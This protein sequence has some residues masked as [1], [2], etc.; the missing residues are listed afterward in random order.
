[1]R[2]EGT[3]SAILDAAVELG[4]LRG[5]EELSLGRLASAVGMSKS[6][7]FAHFGSKEELQLATVAQAWEVFEAE[8]LRESLDDAPPGLGELL[9]RWLSF[10]ERRVF[11]GGC[12]F[13]GSATEFASRQ[14]AVSEALANAV[15]QQLAALDAAVRRAN[16]SGELEI[17]RAPGRTAFG[18]FSILVNS[19]SLFHL[20]EDPAAFAR[21]RAA[22]D[23]LLDQATAPERTPTGP[24]PAAPEDS[25]LSSY[26]RVDS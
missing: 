3:R 16:K 12:F 15:E 17:T 22:I 26:A 4:S 14:D 24:D 23:E 21:A 19:D 20:R 18:L 9:E 2:V 8:V 5:L 11:I 10:Y 13:V 7:L 25:T 6:G 1:M